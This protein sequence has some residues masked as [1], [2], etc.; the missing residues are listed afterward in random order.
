MYGAYGRDP[1]LDYQPALQPLLRRGVA[2]AVAH[3]RGGGC[4]GPAWY[5]AGRGHGAKA[6]SHEDLLAAARQ[7][8]AAGVTRPELMCLEAESAGAQG[9]PRVRCSS[10]RYPL[11]ILW[12]VPS[13]GKSSYRV[14]SSSCPS[15]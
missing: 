12:V 9:G 6:R 15:A 8:V 1:L 10:C 13:V 3:V 14:P 7:L 11:I 2:V 5:E 4:L